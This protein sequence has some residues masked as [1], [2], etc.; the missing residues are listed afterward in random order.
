M[1]WNMEINLNN[2]VINRVIFFIKLIKLI[3]FFLVGEGYLN[4]MGNEFG[5]FEWID[6]LW[7]GNNWSYKYVRR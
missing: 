7:E 5:Y 6:F 3:I 1:Y 2:Y 4:F